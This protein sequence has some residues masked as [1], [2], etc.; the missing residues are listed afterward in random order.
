MAITNT[1]LRFFIY[2][3]KQG[4]SFRKTA[5]LGRLE[6]KISQNLPLD[7]KSRHPDLINPEI[8]NFEEKF[9][10]T[11]FHSLGAEIVESL[12]YSN[13]ERANI[14]ADLNLPLPAELHNKYTVLVD[15]GTLEHVFNFPQAIMNCMNLIQPGG[16]FIGFSPANN[17][18]G[19]GFYQFSPELYYRVFSKENGF[20]ETQVFMISAGFE[21]D[22]INMFTVADPESI[23]ERVT[24]TST[25]PGYLL[26][27]SRKI[28]QTSTNPFIVYQ[29]DYTGLWNNQPVFAAKSNKIPLLKRITGR[30][31]RMI[32]GKL[33]PENLEEINPDYFKIKKI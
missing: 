30:I 7:L 4:V 31:K 5:T 23:R 28:Q 12:D 8:I 26:V 18:M 33:K 1:C 14:I 17:L 29:S 10:E 32:K 15:G 16:H 3:K 20:G 2:G 24:L 19:H 27:I 21:T 9:G 13:Y 11:V 22:T 25:Q 6:N